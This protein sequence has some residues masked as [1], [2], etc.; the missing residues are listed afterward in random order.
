MIFGERIATVALSQGW[1]FGP[2]DVAGPAAAR[3][4]DLGRLSC[5]LGGAALLL[6]IAALIWATIRFR[7]GAH[8]KPRI[9][10]S[11]ALALALWSGACV[12][13]LALLALPSLGA[14]FS[15]AAGAKPDLTVTV[16]GRTGYWTYAYTSEGDF[17]FD[18]H[19]LNAKTAQTYR[20]PYMKAVDYPMVV[21]VNR[22]VE[23]LA[24]GADVVHYWSIPALGVGVDA[25]PGR[26]NSIRFRANKTG[27]YYGLC[28]EACG[29][30]GVAVPAAVKVVGEEEYL[31][32]LTW[33]HQAYAAGDAPAAIVAAR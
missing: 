23:I 9:S 13:A 7:A 30:A 25:V 8:P 12:V 21:P 10:P 17:R 5:A 3:L 2:P 27:L 1:P 32:W 15:S 6:L 22:T 4:Y 14:L 28:A 19:R 26:I 31:G 33:A 20:Q 11:Q 18:S 16:I 24:T 29:A